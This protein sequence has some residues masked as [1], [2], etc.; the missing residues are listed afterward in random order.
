V[1]YLRHIFEVFRSSS[2]IYMSRRPTARSEGSG[3]VPG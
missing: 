3:R 2:R 1:G